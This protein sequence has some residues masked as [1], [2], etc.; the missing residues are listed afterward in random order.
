MRY[1]FRILAIVYLIFWIVLIV[2]DINSTLDASY[3]GFWDA[4]LV[5]LSLAVNMTLGYLAG[6]EAEH[7]YRIKH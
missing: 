5:I 1:F 3:M 4:I 7:E 2:P 6:R